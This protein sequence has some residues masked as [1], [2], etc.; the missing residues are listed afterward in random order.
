MPNTD[1]NLTTAF[2]LL[3]SAARYELAADFLEIRDN[4]GAKDG[5]RDRANAALIFLTDAQK[6]AQ[7]RERAEFKASLRNP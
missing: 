7:D 4:A 5:D 1:D 2:A 3:R 6:L